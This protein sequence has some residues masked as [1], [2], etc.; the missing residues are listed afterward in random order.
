MMDD[1]SDIKGKMIARL[2]QD[3]KGKKGLESRIET[4]NLYEANAEK[5]KKINIKE[6]FGFYKQLKDGTE[7]KILMFPDIEEMHTDERHV[8]SWVDYS[9]FDAEITYFLR[10][11]LSYQLCQLKT[12]EEDMLDMSGLYSKYWL[13]FGELLT[14]MERIGF[15]IDLDYLKQIE[16]M[17]KRDQIEYEQN[18]MQWVHSIQ[19]DAQEFNPS[20]VQQLQQLLFAPFNKKK[21]DQ[22]PEG[23]FEFAQVREFRVENTSVRA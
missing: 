2:R 13:P 22:T 9:T 12:G 15:K 3:Y 20:S 11:T 21:S 17:A 7:G 14:D 18:F 8:Q 10:E 1:I 6:T 4:L 5:I 23:E 16:L 19:E